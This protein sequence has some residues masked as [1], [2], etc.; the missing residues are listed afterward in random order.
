MTTTLS[1]CIS[2]TANLLFS[3]LEIIVICSQ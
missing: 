3:E 2:L 1:L